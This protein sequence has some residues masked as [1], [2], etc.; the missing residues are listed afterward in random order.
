MEDLQ[1]EW[2]KM[3]DVYMSV[4]YIAAASFSANPCTINEKVVLTVTVTEQ[5]IL[6]DPEVIYAGEIF[7]GER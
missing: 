1:E 2:C 4:P 6:L 5:N 3:A 7:A